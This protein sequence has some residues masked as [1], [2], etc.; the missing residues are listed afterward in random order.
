VGI[1][2][3]DM[4]E[5]SIPFEDKMLLLL[6]LMTQEQ[7]DSYRRR[8][9]LDVSD[10]WECPSVVKQ[11]LET[12]D[13]SIRLDAIFSARASAELEYVCRVSRQSS[14]DALCSSLDARATMVVVSSAVNASFY[15]DS[16]KQKYLDWA[17]ELLLEKQSE[18]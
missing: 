16:A 11:W 6:L 3:D 17:V 7:L 9:A 12:G 18:K 1:I 5:L 4:K 15:S 10:S 13:E 8:V 14:M 2:I